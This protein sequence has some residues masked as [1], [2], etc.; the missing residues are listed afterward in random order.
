MTFISVNCRFLEVEVPAFIRV[1]ELFRDDP[2]TTRVRILFSS[3]P[4]IHSVV[5]STGWRNNHALSAANLYI[6]R[7][8]A[9]RYTAQ[10]DSRVPVALKKQLLVMLGSDVTLTVRLWFTGPTFASNSF[11]R[12]F[13]R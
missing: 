5:S 7:E 6:E 11:T 9:K 8:F 2:R 1:I 12:P 10:E 4:S 3:G 13:F